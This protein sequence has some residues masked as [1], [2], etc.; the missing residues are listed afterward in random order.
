M[1]FPI[2]LVKLLP[3]DGNHLVLLTVMFVPYR[4]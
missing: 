4:V 3:N 1:P 2:W